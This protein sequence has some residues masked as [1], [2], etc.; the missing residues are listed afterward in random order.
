VFVSLSSHFLIRYIVEA[1]VDMRQKDKEDGGGVNENGDQSAM[2]ARALLSILRLSQALARLHF[3]DVVRNEDVEEAIRITHMSKASL[4]DQQDGG[5]GGSNQQGV[6]HDQTSKIFGVMRDAAVSAN[7][8]SLNFQDIEAAVLR[9]GFQLDAFYET[10]E[11][12]QQLNVI[13]VDAQRTRID[14]VG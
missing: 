2:T 13:M 6:S 7:S 5:S 1:F 9:K 10:L 4:M 14:F 11:E 8:A 3:S 12:Y